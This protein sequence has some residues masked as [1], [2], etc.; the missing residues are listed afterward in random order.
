[1]SSNVT[2]KNTNKTDKAINCLQ[3]SIEMF[4]F[5]DTVLLCFFV[6]KVLLSIISSHSSVNK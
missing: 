2:L 3:E 6:N 4:S 1:M 5:I